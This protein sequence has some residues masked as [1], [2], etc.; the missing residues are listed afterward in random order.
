MTFNELIAV[1]IAEYGSLNQ[2]ML[3]E[4]TGICRNCGYIQD[5]VEPDAECYECEDC[6]KFEVCGIEHL[7]LIAG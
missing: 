1:L 5:G 2:A 6:G 3:E 4:T 7:I